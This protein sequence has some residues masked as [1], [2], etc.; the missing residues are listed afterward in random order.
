MPDTG[1]LETYIRPQGNNVRVDDGY[2]QGMDIPIFYDPMIAKL[3][4][5]GQTREE[6]RERLIRAINEYR[7]KGIRTTLPFGKWALQQPAFIT[8]Q[9]DTNFIGKYFTP[10]S[11]RAENSEAAQAAAILAVQLWQRVTAAQ[12]PV[13]QP[14]NW[15]LRRNLR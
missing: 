3:I 6:A 12:Q 9:F 2:E 7:V 5:W 8:G 14:S 1:K 11:L 4:A 10:Q 15:K 13:P